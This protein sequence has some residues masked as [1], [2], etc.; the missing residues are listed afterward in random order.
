MYVAQTKYQVVR[1]VAKN[2]FKMRLT[3]DETEDWDICWQDGAVQCE[4]LYKM[5]PY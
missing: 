3:T 1:Y 5:K 4:K 2:I